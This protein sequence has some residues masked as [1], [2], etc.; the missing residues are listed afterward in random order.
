MHGY[1]HLTVSQLRDQLADYMSCYPDQYRSHDIGRDA[2]SNTHWKKYMKELRNG[3]HGDSIMMRAMT[4]ML[5]TT[6]ELLEFDSTWDFILQVDP[7]NESDYSFGDPVDDTFYLALVDVTSEHYVSL[8]PKSWHKD[9][10]DIIEDQ[11]AFD[12]ACIKRCS[13]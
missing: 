7:T 9:K 6:T 13:T 2:I 3:S 1:L 12:A 11:E 5:Q 10:Y 4:D 8:K